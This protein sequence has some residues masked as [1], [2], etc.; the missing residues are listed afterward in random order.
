MDAGD[1]DG[2]GPSSGRVVYKLEDGETPSTGVARAVAR[3]EGCEP[4]DLPPLY[5]AIDPGALDSLFDSTNPDRSVETAF[6][7]DGYEVR[8]SQDGT[9]STVIVDEA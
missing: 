3:A 4:T 7:L 6:R 5:D 2:I 1:A 8:I 9:D